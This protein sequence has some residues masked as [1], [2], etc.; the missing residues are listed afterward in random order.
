MPWM[1][2]G[3]RWSSAAVWYPL[4]LLTMIM[5]SALLST[6]PWQWMETTTAATMKSKIITLT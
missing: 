1:V 3:R 2:E 5:P 6:Q 4:T